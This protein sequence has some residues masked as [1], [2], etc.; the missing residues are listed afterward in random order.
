MIT[1]RGE[2]ERIIEY[3]AVLK[4]RNDMKLRYFAFMA[5]GVGKTSLGGQSIAGQWDVNTLRMALGGVHGVKF[6]DFFS[7]KHFY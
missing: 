6:G 2:E 1:V 7:A 3:L 4:L 5:S